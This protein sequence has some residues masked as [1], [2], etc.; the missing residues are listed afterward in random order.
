MNTKLEIEKS[1]MRD[2]EHLISK[3]E[4]LSERYL[5]AYIRTCG[6]DTQ[7][8]QMYYLNSIS[9][10]DRFVKDVKHMK[11]DNNYELLKI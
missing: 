4:N 7:K 1:I 10:I 5:K 8:L 3:L 2:K 6:N 9:M 11:I